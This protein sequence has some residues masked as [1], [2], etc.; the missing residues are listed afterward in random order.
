[1]R[2]L[3]PELW[4]RIEPILDDL[5]DLPRSQ[6]QGALEQ[7]CGG[8][9][10]L[11]RELESL[12]PHSGSAGDDGTNLVTLAPG[13]P[14]SE[15]ATAGR[16]IGPY[17]VERLL[18]RGGMGSV[19]L[20]L[21]VDEFEK[22]VAIKL[23]R[24]GLSTAVVIRRFHHERQ[25]LA[26]LDHPNI[27]KLLDGGTTEDGL[28][29]FVMEYVEGEPLD[30]YCHRGGLSVRERLE[31]FRKVCSAVHLAHQNLIVHRDLKPGNIL[32]DADGE[33]KLLDFGIAKPLDAASDAA[34]EMTGAG[35]QPMTVAYASPEQVGN[36]AI[37][38][39]SDVYSL[40][41]VLYELLTGRR[42]YR[43]S[44]NK[45]L[46]LVRAIEEQEPQK[47]SIAA[48][49]A[50]PSPPATTV[51]VGDPDSDTDTQVPGSVQRERV[52][53]RHGWRRRLAG[54][55]DSIVLTALHKQ[56]ERRYASVE[57]FSADVRR[58]LVGLPVT[59]R[60][61]TLAYRAGKFVRRHRIETALAALVLAS[62]LVFTLFTLR[63]KNE[64][65]ELKNEAVGLKNAAIQE[66]DRAE[67]VSGFLVDLFKAPS[68]DQAKGEDVTARQL[69]DRGRD[70]IESYRDGSPRLSAQLA[71]T[72]AESYYN[73]GHYGDAR[74]LLENAVL[75]L[76]EHSGGRAG[77]QLAGA[78]N[79]L[80]A[81]LWA[82]GDL[83]SA[84]A[85]LRESLEMK[86]QLYGE[87]SL[88]LF[89]T[90]NNLG[91]LASARGAFQDA[92]VYYRRALAIALEQPTPDPD[93]IARSHFVLGTLFLEKGDYAD[94]EASLRRA[95]DM[96]RALYGAEHTGV[97]TVLNN[98]GIALHA[99]AKMTESEDILREAL[100]TRRALLDEHHPL[101]GTTETNLASLLVTRGKLEE[102]ESLVF[103]ALATLRD[104]RPDHW[105]VAHAESV[106]GSC[107][108][109]T[110]RFAEA[111]VLLVRSYPVLVA[112][113]RECTRYTVEALSRMRDL[114]SAWGKR[115]ETD[116]YRTRLRTCA[117]GT[118]APMRA[119]P[120]GAKPR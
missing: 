65:V 32:V 9:L 5:L 28:P 53:D 64:A 51:T 105:R 36:R 16:R 78:V 113:K 80:A 106:L 2:P 11:K 40:G 112:A 56:P 90:L 119:S 88:E 37:T 102:A 111:E 116:T 23:L 58:H 3:T 117:S 10:E 94:A 18:G 44:S 115:G 97:A 47:P 96:R 73:L 108:A 27:A 12:L 67:E 17:R 39:A 110:E 49:G 55:L 87:D 100:E 59:A 25:I 60:K 43:P 50:P 71:S 13:R 82:Q 14:G 118:D 104:S 22:R 34:S 31:L 76:R 54:D 46:D 15:A 103:K 93:V 8:D 33:P 30:R 66:R 19:F 20:A 48:S 95:L 101:V 62:N 81:V 45:W 6:Q 41:V 114:Y 21:R 107:L 74:Q 84:E 99:Q 98:L 38:T 24:P 35:V 26:N 85:Y 92:E 83:P 1:M 70:R 4:Q 61:I 7:A 75:D 69:L 42:P 120:S 68:P 91:T 63:L 52:I 109:G 72:M 77:T 29:Y 57:Q 89:R 86:V 79:D